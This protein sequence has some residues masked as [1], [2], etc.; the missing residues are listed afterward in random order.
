MSSL[1]KILQI[2]RQTKG[3]KDKTTLHLDISNVNNIFHYIISGISNHN[4]LNFM[5]KGQP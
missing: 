1:N 5:G 2:R 3:N 4:W